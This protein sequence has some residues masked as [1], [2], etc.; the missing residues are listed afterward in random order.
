MTR[1]HDQVTENQ[2]GPRAQAY[3]DSAVH[4]S[5]DDLDALSEIVRLAAPE[6]ALDIGAGGGHVT[7]RLAEHARAVTAIDLS[8]EMLAAVSTNAALRGLD[9]VRTVHAPAEKL[10]FDD[11]SFDFLACRFSAHHWRAFE[12]GLA[13]ARRVVVSGAPVIFIDVISPGPALLD[14]HLQA[15]ELLRDTSHVRDYAPEEWTQALA[16]HDLRVTSTRRWRL[17]MDFAVWVA[18]MNTPSLHAQAIRAL[19]TAAASEVV[20][21]FAIEPDGSFSIDVMMFEATAG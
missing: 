20:E 2:F 15:V 7:Y 19:Q 12:Q 5:G 16:R 13:E 14:T 11:A 1:Q 10:P 8:S 3:V 9:N 21:H 4:A 17:R 18:R 6:R